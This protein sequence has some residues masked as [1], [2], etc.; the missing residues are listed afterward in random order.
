MTQLGIAQASSFEQAGGAFRGDPGPS[1]PLAPSDSDQCDLNLPCG[2]PGTTVGAA[3]LLP[4]ALHQAQLGVGTSEQQE[5]SS[6]QPRPFACHLCYKSFGFHSQLQVHLRSHTKE[7][8]F[9]CPHCH[10]GFSQKGNYN[11]HLRIHL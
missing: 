8:P 10:K 4:L 6:R 1:E 11:R 7:T 3:P 2:P 5:A 9:R